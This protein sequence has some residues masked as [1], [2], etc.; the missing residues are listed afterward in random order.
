[1]SRILDPK[2]TYVPSH[3]TNLHKTFARLRR[4]RKQEEEARAAAEA[5]AKAKVRTIKRS[6]KGE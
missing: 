6:A 2:W 3:E 4:E 5:E 1:M